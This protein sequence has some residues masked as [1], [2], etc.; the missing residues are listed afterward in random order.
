MGEE[1]ISHNKHLSSPTVVWACPNARENLSYRRVNLPKRRMTSRQRIPSRKQFPPQCTASEIWAQGIK[2][3]DRLCA[4]NLRS[5]SEQE[6]PHHGHECP[7]V[8]NELC[9]FA[10]IPPS[11]IRI[12][13]VAMVVFP[14]SKLSSLSHHLRMYKPG[15]AS[16]FI[17]RSA[18]LVKASHG[19]RLRY[20]GHA[21]HF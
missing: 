16:V 1:Q 18:R 19:K 15:G 8:K 2:R 17:S 3:R 10:F 12:H 7:K 21:K 6:T 9:R 20:F 5:T 4:G 11:L 13:G 14:M